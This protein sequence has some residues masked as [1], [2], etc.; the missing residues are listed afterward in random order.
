MSDPVIFQKSPIVQET[1]AGTYWWCTC[2]R[3]ASQPFCDGSH[4]GSQF[5]PI[6]VEINPGKTVAWC[7]CK[8]SKNKPFCDGSHCQ[9]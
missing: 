4:Q 5:S 2:G 3:S 9:L 8:H 7:A 1:Q 6:E